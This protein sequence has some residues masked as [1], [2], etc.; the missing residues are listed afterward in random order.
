MSKNRV[1]KNGYTLDVTPSKD[2]TIVNDGN[3]VHIT[4]NGK[5][6]TLIII[7]IEKLWSKYISDAF[8]LLI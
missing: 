7:N 6:P 3:F 2:I 8:S 5:E 4:Y 1:Y